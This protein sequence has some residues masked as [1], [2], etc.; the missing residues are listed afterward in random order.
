MFSLAI[1]W[2]YS[3]FIIWSIKCLIIVKNL[4]FSCLLR[5]QIDSSIACFVP[6]TLQS[7]NIWN[8]LSHKT[9]KSNKS[10]QLRSWKHKTFG[11]FA[12]KMTLSIIK[13]GADYFFWQLTH[14]LIN[15]SFH[16]SNRSVPV[17]H[18]SKPALAK[19]ELWNLHSYMETIIKVFKYTCASHVTT[20]QNVCSEK[21]CY[22][23]EER[24][25][26]EEKSP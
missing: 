21:T 14:W 5:A 20:R 4:N 13:I 22:L 8:L 11:S 17:S 19:P 2:I 6:S 23:C 18:T 26:Q 3:R 12:W 10:S 7:P 9:N 16:D 25:E 15:Q 24:K 1:C